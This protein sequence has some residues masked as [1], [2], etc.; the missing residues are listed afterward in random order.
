MPPG[1]IYVGRPSTWGNQYDWRE[2]GK[3]QA[4]QMFEEDIDEYDKELIKHDLAGKDLV[5][6][7][8]LDEPCHADILLKIA[9]QSHKLKERDERKTIL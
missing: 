3:E 2:Y 6:W 1:A 4:A 8:G 5:C 7:C 9:N